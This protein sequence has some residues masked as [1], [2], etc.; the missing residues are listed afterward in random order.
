MNLTRKLAT[1]YGRLTPA[2]IDAARAI[3]RKRR[4]LVLAT[5]LVLT[6]NVGCACATSSQDQVCETQGATQ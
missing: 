3:A 6:V 1:T 2:N 4:A 5:A